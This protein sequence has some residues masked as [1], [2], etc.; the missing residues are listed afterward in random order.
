MSKYEAK[1]VFNQLAE[2]YLIACNR[3]PEAQTYVNDLRRDHHY[4]VDDHFFNKDRKE[5]SRK[6]LKNDVKGVAKR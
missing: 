5:H 1:R 3:S 6:A 4:A 2:S